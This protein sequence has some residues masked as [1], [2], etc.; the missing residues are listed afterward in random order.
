MALLKAAPETPVT[1]T[2]G[3]SE[4]LL[5]AL[6][7]SRA[8]ERRAA[9]RALASRPD[10]FEPLACAL[11]QENEAV[12]VTALFAALG[13]M[14][15][16]RYVDLLASLLASD[17]ALVRN[18][19]VEAWQALGEDE[20]VRAAQLL[21]HADPDVRIFAISVLRAVP[22]RRAEPPLL[23]LLDTEADPNVCAAAVDLLAEV[24]S[25][26]AVDRLRSLAQRFVDE[27][28]LRFAID[29]AIAQMG[30]RK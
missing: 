1:E 18:Q 7:S 23:A 4:A 21:A 17:D 20:A 22:V 11:R 29:F 15:D 25:S 9:A 19:A 14:R 13:A 28:S 30:G 6:E 26:T 3:T 5:H 10:A 2:N 8:E 27:D 24:G 12:V 16:Q